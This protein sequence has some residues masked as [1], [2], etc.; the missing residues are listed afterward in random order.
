[1]DVI[2]LMNDLRDKLRSNDRKQVLSPTQ[3]V[4][5]RGLEPHN[6]PAGNGAGLDEGEILAGD[7]RRE[8]E[9]LDRE[10]MESWRN[11]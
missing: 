10:E 6:L 2:R 5:L 7:P 11:S 4:W 8:S 1:M 9:Y 3:R